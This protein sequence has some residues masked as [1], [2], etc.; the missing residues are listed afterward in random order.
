MAASHGIVLARCVNPNCPCLMVPNYDN[1]NGPESVGWNRHWTKEEHWLGVA[2]GAPAPRC[3]F[4][5]QPLAVADGGERS[6]RNTASR[7][8]TWR[9]YAIPAGTAAHVHVLQSHDPA[10]VDAAWGEWKPIV[11]KNAHSFTS[12]T[13]ARPGYWTFALAVGG[14]YYEVE[15]SQLDIQVTR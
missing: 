2:G 5:G 7:G 10:A 1:P 15:F 14:R 4:C 6:G 13:R 8:N 11:T 12:R 9:T 3:G